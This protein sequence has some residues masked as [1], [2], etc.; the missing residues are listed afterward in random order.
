ML[1][2]GIRGEARTYED[3]VT[4]Q[5][6][7]YIKDNTRYSGEIA[8]YRDEELGMYGDT[9]HL[10]KLQKTENVIEPTNWEASLKTLLDKALTLGKDKDTLQ[11][12]QDL[13]DSI[14]LNNPS[15]FTPLNPNYPKIKEIVNEYQER[16]NTLIAQSPQDIKFVDTKGKEHTLNKDTQKQWLQTFGLQ[17]LEQSY[18]PKHSQAIQQALG[19]K[20]I[21]LTKGS[22]LKLVSKERE[23]YIPQVKE[24]LDNPDYILKDIDGMI[25][26]AKKIDDKQYFTSINLETDDFLI[27]I[28]NAPKKENILK[29]KVEKG[30]KIIYQSPNSESIFYTPELLQA[31][32]SLAN[33]IDSS[34]S[35]IK[36]QSKQLKGQEELK[37]IF[38]EFEQQDKTLQDKAKLL[39][40][41]KEDLKSKDLVG[42]EK[43]ESLMEQQSLLIDEESQ[44]LERAYKKAKRLMPHF[45]SYEEILQYEPINK[46]S[47]KLLKENV[48]E[49]MDKEIRALQDTSITK[50][51]F[52]QALDEFNTFYKEYRD[53]HKPLYY[54]FETKFGFYTRE[55]NKQK[56][57]NAKDVEMF[58]K[59]FLDKKPSEFNDKL[60]QVYETIQQYNQLE[61]QNRQRI[62]DSKESELIKSKAIEIKEQLNNKYK[63]SIQKQEISKQSENPHAQN[64]DQVTNSKE[65]E[66]GNNLSLMDSAPNPTTKDLIKQAKEQG[67]SVKETKEA[68]QDSTQATQDLT[69]LKQK[70]ENAS[71]EEK[72]EI[73]KEAITEQNNKLLEEI[74][75]LQNVLEKKDFL[76]FEIDEK[77]K[78]LS[79]K[80]QFI[81]EDE[82]SLKKVAISQLE[83]ETK[84]KIKEL[85]K[86]LKDNKI[87]LGT[88]KEFLTKAKDPKII[89]N[90]TAYESV[91]ATLKRL[92]EKNQKRVL[93]IL[94][95]AIQERKLTYYL[96]TKDG[97][98]RGRK[99]F[100]SFK[101]DTEQIELFEKIF[102]IAQKLGVEVKQA[103][104]NEFLSKEADGVYYSQGNSLRVKNNRIYQEKGKVFLHEL[105]HSVTSRAMI[106]Y[107]SGKKELLSPN[108]IVAINN[109]QKLYKE[110]HKNHKELGFETFESFFTGHKG[111]YGL[112]NSHEF[113]AELSNPIFRE[114]LKKVGVFEKLVD[115]IL[116]LFVSAK[117]ALGLAKTN[118]YDSLKRSLYE[119]I[120]NYK[121]DFTANYEKQGIKEL[122]IKQSKKL[123]KVFLDSDN[124][125]IEALEAEAV[126]LPK[127]LKEIEFIRSAKKDSK[128]YFVDT[129][130]GRV[131]F[132]NILK[133]YRHLYENTYMQD[134]RELSGAFMET[135]K[136][137]LFVV[138]QKYPLNSTALTQAKHSQITPS[139][140]SHKK[141]TK[142]LNGEVKTKSIIQDSYVFYKPFVNENGLVSLASFAISQNGELLHKT[143]YD[144]KTLSKLKKLIKGDDED[145]LYFKNSNVLLNPQE[146]KTI[147]KIQKTYN[148]NEAKAKDLYEWH[149]DS[150]PITK[151]KNGLPKVFYHGSW[152][153]FEV[154]QKELT[155][156]Y[157][158]PQGSYFS[159]NK[160]VAK[161]YGETL[162]ES[163]LKVKNPFIIE[164]FGETFEYSRD[165]I[166]DKI[167]NIDLSKYDSIILKNIKD[168]PN[169]SGGKLADT[170]IIFDSNQIKHIDNQ[171][172]YT[173]IQGNITKEKPKDTEAEH[174][175]FN[176][177]SPNIYQ[178]NA[179][180]GSGLVSGTLAGV[181][182]DENGN[183]V[184]FDPSKF[185][186]GFLGGSVASKIG[187]E[188]IKRLSHNP[189][190]RE[191]LERLRLKN[192]IL[193]LLNKGKKVDSKDVI[194]ILQ[195]SPQKGRDMFVIGQDNLTQ[196]V[197]EW[198][199][200]NN[201]KIAVD[202]LDSSK[203]KSLGFKY[204]KE[205][206]R[207]IGASEINHTLS[208][209]GAKSQLV[210]KSGQKEVKLDDISQWTKYA[211][212]ADKHIISKDDLGQEVLVSA[213]QINGYYVIVESIRKKHNELAFKTMYFE[214]GK[215]QDNEMFK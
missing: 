16:L 28:S 57:S 182:R 153:E 144:I 19:G 78:W 194:K 104:N 9:F 156:D 180:I 83:F 55:F 13:M 151:D 123:E 114:K 58:K 112:K 39:K 91:K 175:Y 115:N 103:I 109:I 14:H 52:K 2:K 161:Q 62:H 150:N 68:M 92:I 187:L 41:H 157:E 131:D 120:D 20:E 143:F 79:T 21:R 72:G 204:P 178:T 44:I 202:T 32:Q 50:A 193:P 99:L 36:E 46:V 106:A 198:V 66:S 149:K 43:W 155:R 139:P 84:D 60:K 137:P 101:P 192:D 169:G 45:S 69:H 195:T 203:A 146:L 29:N 116:R 176:E 125:N 172:S 53:Y 6:I 181:E 77:I 4:K 108:Q 82:E 208:R 171:G 22:L 100:Y 80:S 71:D 90:K 1:T 174:R 145:L 173:D 86:I 30:A 154:F 105:I 126:K 31:S 118:A 107:E 201:K 117:E 215:I 74:T 113:V 152:K 49:I 102:P 162:Y 188:S 134:R 63:N 212:T 42:G 129:P 51:D 186:L 85:Q 26:L 185:A 7:E 196:D 3:G 163:F 76:P 168:N 33:K 191:V 35:T 190:A 130:I 27:S 197:L 211:D 5:D 18:I 189:K 165:Y 128:G 160:A 12:A 159:S 199:I 59:H 64:F 37:N 206:R 132:K 81:G 38:D 94:D 111:D 70:L 138:R 93:K 48:N 56:L 8:N 184:G 148:F 133:T 164:N 110:V 23:Q 96:N 61:L 147:S 214:N 127:E 97:E 98:E 73:I 200:K 209:H 170:I 124:I 210:Q 89:E 140:S 177:A 179:H 11:Q 87:G 24:T 10:S 65:L 95:N 141:N 166:I 207:T 122:D 67:L 75:K 167:A 135:L 121:D 119:I 15:F 136:N 142:S 47:L 88:L 158:M 34:N 40:E 205:V 54:E 213:K 17:N 183:I 25:I